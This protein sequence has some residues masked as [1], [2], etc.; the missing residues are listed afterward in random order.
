MQGISKCLI[1][2]RH[3]V[4]NLIS[5]QTQFFHIKCPNFT[6]PSNR[7]HSSSSLL[8]KRT[9]RNAFL[10]FCLLTFSLLL[11]VV[12]MPPELYESL[13]MTFR[14]LSIQAA[15]TIPGVTRPEIFRC[16][17]FKFRFSA[18]F[19]CN[20]LLIAES[21]N[22][23]VAAI[24]PHHCWVI[25]AYA[26]ILTAAIISPGDLNVHFQ[27]DSTDSFKRP[28]MHPKQ[29]PIKMLP[30]SIVMWFNSPKTEFQSRSLPNSGP[31]W[32]ILISFHS[33]YNN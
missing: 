2:S 21:R 15:R 27:C 14:F 7:F 24:N 11:I 19:F 30:R 17:A 6:D 10:T 23:F 26:W 9:I 1:S 22:L 12:F 33:I 29:F 32:K 16:W 8:G 28:H 25:Y 20:T 13:W 4:V 5:G 31:S 3:A 18:F